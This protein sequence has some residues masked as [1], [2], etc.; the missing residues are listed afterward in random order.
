MNVF[1]SFNFSDEKGSGFGN[2]M[3]QTS[4]K[5]PLPLSEIRRFEREL[6]ELRGFKSVVILNVIQLEGDE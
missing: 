6:K 3:F 5:F 1:C 2:A 4:E